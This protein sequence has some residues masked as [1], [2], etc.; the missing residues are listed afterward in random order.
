ME[1]NFEWFRTWR[2]SNG[3]RP[4]D[5]RRAQVRRHLVRGR[6][7]GPP[8]TAVGRVRVHVDL[9]RDLRSLRRSPQRL[10]QPGGPLEV[11]RRADHRVPGVVHQ[12]GHR[13]RQPAVLGQVARHRPQRIDRRGCRPRALDRPQHGDHGSPVTGRTSA[14]AAPAPPRADRGPPRAAHAVSVSPSAQVIG[15]LPGFGAGEQRPSRAGLADSSEEPKLAPRQ[16]DEEPPVQEPVRPL[17]GRLRR[18][19]A[20][21]ARRPVQEVLRVHR[22]PPGADRVRRAPRR[23]LQRRRDDLLQPLRSRSGATRPPSVPSLSDA[24]V[25]ISS[26]AAGGRSSV[27]GHAYSR[28][29]RLAA[30]YPHCMAISRISTCASVCTSQ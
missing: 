26:P 16:V 27:A 19:H 15:D 6:R 2:P 21:V 3:F 8:T 9:H 25:T 24:V 18:H 23:P 20:A 7:P 14:E 22:R 1:R 11:E 5:H 17:A 30:E 29:L 10:P 13:V 12:V 4:Q 28:S